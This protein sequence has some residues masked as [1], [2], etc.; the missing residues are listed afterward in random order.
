MQLIVSAL[1]IAA[2][3][4]WGLLDPTGMSAFFDGALAQLTRKLGWLY[5][6]VVLGL[7]LT[8]LA[9]ALAFG[10]VGRL[11]LGGEDEEPAFSRG[12]WFAML[13]AAGMGIGLVFWGVAEP[14]SHYINPPPGLAPR[15]PEAANAAMR[16]SFFHWGRHPWAV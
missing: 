7:V 2:L 4:L 3:V 13:F 12:A 8:S 11:K 1:V 10:R 5:L 6:W 14:L 9:L 16:Y 15:T